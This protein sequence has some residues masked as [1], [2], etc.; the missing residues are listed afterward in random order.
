MERDSRGVSESA[1]VA[2]LIA[3]TV[4]VAGSVGLAVVLADDSTGQ[5]IT[6]NFTYEFFE[7][8]G[9]LIISYDR[10][11]NLTAGNLTVSGPRN[12]VTWAELAGA[13]PDQVVNEN[14]NSIVQVTE[15]S[16]YG[17]GLL[18]DD[19]FRLVYTSADGN[20]T[21]LKSCEADC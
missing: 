18:A 13:T 19:E 14:A 3:I 15:Q 16:A 6:A 17:S 5:G 8:Q 10:G 4:L 11:D 20:V 21:V 9:R 2:T 7:E 12:N 1:G